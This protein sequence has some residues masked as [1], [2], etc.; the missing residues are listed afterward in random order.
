M[1][2]SPTS[3]DMSPGLGTEVLHS[4]FVHQDSSARDSGTSIEALGST[5]LDLGPMPMLLLR[6]QVP[7]LEWGPIEARPKIMVP[8]LGF[9]IGR[10]QV[11][12]HK[13]CTC[14]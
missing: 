5:S 10:A 6:T 13:Q 2:L 1:D 3:M 8:M 12:A 4:T 7:V 9:L 11:L 14:I